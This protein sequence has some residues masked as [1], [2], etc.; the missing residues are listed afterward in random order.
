MPE[1][2]VDWDD[3]R[4]LHVAAMEGS[5]L[6]SARRLGVS[7]ATV[8]RRLARL[9]T[10]L[11]LRLVDRMPTGAVLTAEG[12]DLGELA[13][14]MADDAV[15]LIRRAKGARQGLTGEV[16]VAAPPGLAGAVV[17]PAL[18]SLGAEHP[19]LVLTIASAVPLV[20]LDRLEADLA[21]RLTR[22]E[23]ASHTRRR[24][25]TMR[26]GLFVAETYESG[27]AGPRFI[28][29]A[30]RFDALPQQRWLLEQAGRAGLAVRIDD[31]V[32]QRAAAL[33][34][35]G[36]ALLPE[37]MVGA[38]EG[39]LRAVPWDG[40]LPRREI[41]LAQHQDTRRAPAARL[42]ADRLVAAFERDERF[43]ED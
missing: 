27:T 5:M 14:R 34:G 32:G 16:V 21:I 6:A 13:A 30:Q 19:A 20:S 8:S 39:R 28:G 43:R 18:A 4:I 1:R 24:L 42:V 11:G 7:H 37:F 41:W 15:A 33:A 40:P 35:M 36:I 2:T 29:Y 22:P 3:L 9:E 23:E 10:V 26:F 12:R 38:A 17:V 31:I 25:G